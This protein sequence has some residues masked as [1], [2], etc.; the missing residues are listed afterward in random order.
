M[1]IVFVDIIAD[2]KT[3]KKTTSY[4]HRIVL[5]R[6]KTQH[7]TCFYVIILF[8]SAENCK[9]KCDIILS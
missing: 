9:T 7:F 4:N 2:I 5:K 3:N 6:K 8:Q 1:L